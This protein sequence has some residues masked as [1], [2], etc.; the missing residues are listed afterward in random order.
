[1]SWQWEHGAEYAVPD[2]ILNAADLADLSWRND[3]C[4]SFGRTVTDPVS[5]DAHDVRLWVEHPDPEQR[6]SGGLGERFVVNYQ[7]WSAV[8]VVGL[9][10]VDYGDL[11]AGDDV[12]AALAAW[13]SAQA[14]IVAEVQRRAGA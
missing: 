4:P 14:V 1:M 2:E 10:I 6:E 9:T 13:E 5:G 3:T 7:P 11:Y 8:P 12:H